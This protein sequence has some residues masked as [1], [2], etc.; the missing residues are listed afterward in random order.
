MSSRRRSCISTECCY[1]R[2]HVRPSY[3]DS[4]AHSGRWR[5]LS[6]QGITHRDRHIDMRV[7]ETSDCRKQVTAYEGI[8]H[9][10][11]WCSHVDISVQFPAVPGGTSQ[12]IRRS[13]AKTAYALCQPILRGTPGRSHHRV[14]PFSKRCR[15][16][17]RTTT[18]SST[19][20]Q[21]RIGIMLRY[22]ARRS[23]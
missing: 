11:Y 4:G 19:R 10:G 2:S 23:T 12:H 16:Q 13:P 17:R 8:H 7:T 22:A 9:Y 6:D 18:V 15:T 20:Q 21:W 1:H 3:P 5:A 14:D